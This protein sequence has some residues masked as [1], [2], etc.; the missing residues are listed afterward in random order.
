MQNMVL[1]FYIKGDHLFCELCRHQNSVAKEKQERLAKACLL[2]RQLSLQ[3]E[4]KKN[5]SKISRLEDD[6][7]E[8]NLIIAQQ[9]ALLL[10]HGI[11]KAPGNNFNDDDDRILGQI[12]K[13]NNIYIYTIIINFSA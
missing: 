3:E 6:N 13:P 5:E 4:N 9:E 7:L 2:K 1:I 8:K 12:C 11:I 10:K